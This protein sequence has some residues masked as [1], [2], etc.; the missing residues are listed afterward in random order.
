M[1]GE[2]TYLNEEQMAHFHVI[3]SWG[4]PLAPHEIS[5]SSCSVLVYFSLHFISSLFV[6]IQ[7]P[8]TVS[9]SFLTNHNC[10]LWM[11][12]DD[13]N[14][15]DSNTWLKGNELGFPSANVEMNLNPCQ[16]TKPLSLSLPY[17][18]NLLRSIKFSW[19]IMEGKHD[20]HLLRVLIC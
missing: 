10:Q 4:Q 9:A 12:S 15:V 1:E 2:T 5:S 19:S 18:N 7:L 11:E 20:C 17:H 16:I 14:E 3:H 13:Y 6:S 8:G